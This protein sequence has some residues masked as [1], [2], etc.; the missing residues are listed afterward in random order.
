[1]IRLTFVDN[2]I[3]IYQKNLK[4]SMKN[5]FLRHPEPLSTWNIIVDI[6]TSFLNNDMHFLKNVN[7]I[8]SIQNQ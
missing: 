8:N 7:P 4:V 5:V 6:N 1:M 3:L 2:Y